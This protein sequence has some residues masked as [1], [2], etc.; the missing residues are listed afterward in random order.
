MTFRVAYIVGQLSLGGAEQQLYHLLS[1]LNRSRFSPVVITLGPTPDEYWKKPIT[2]LGIPVH[3]VPRCFSRILRTHRIAVI[4]RTAQIKI[5]HS[6]SFHTNPYAALAGRLAGVPLRLGSMRE[7]YRLITDGLVRRLGYRGL[8]A[9]TTNSQSTARQISELRLTP[10]P[11]RFISNGVDIPLPV[12]SGSRLRLKSELGFCDDEILVGNIARLDSNK[13]HAM[14]LRTFAALT[15]KWPQLR[16]VIIGD[17]PLKSQLSS[18][19]HELGIASKVILTGG[20]PLAARYLSAM[21]VCCMTS[22]TEGL[23][24]LVM[25]AMAAGLPVVSTRCGDC[26]DLIESGV[27]GYLVS[28]DDDVSL[29]T[30]LD[31]LLSNSALRSRMGRAG[32]EKMRN[33]YSVEKLARRT[34]RVYDDLVIEKKMLPASDSHKVTVL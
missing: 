3:H 9:L 32:R 33:D 28:V 22:Y 20:R 23:P 6:W 14:L 10:V 19:A 8:D 25:E 4:L 11:V 16:L 1:A 17:G 34:T 26:I 29:A 27:S 12:D 18:M 24:N 31:L 30:H 21:D 7:N 5:V 15:N 2:E 13:N